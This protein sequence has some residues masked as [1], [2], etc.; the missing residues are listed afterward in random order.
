MSRHFMVE[1]NEFV[2][3]D[4]SFDAK[5]PIALKRHALLRCNPAAQKS[6]S[7]MSHGTRDQ[8]TRHMKPTSVQKDRTDERIVPKGLCLAKNPHKPEGRRHYVL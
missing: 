2:A 8:D 4:K 5:D 1:A 6:P 7:K 3:F